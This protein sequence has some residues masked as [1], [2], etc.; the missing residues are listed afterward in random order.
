MEVNLGSSPSVR[1]A[2]LGSS[3]QVDV[4]DPSRGVVFDSVTREVA[5]YVRVCMWAYAGKWRM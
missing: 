2:K 3:V 5:E 4:L 1:Q